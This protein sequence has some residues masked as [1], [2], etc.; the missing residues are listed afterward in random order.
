VAVPYTPGWDPV[1]VSARIK[2]AGELL[3]GTQFRY[4]VAYTK[5]TKKTYNF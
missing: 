3:G 5:A 1:F 2:Y 4:G